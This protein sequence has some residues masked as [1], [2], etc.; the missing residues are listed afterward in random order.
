MIQLPLT[1]P[2]WAA[3]CLDEARIFAGDAG[4][5]SLAIGL[6][7]RNVEQGTGGPFGAAIF[8]RG[9]GELVSIGMNL[10][11]AA[12][13]SVLHAEMVAIMQAEAKIGSFTLASGGSFELFTSCEPCA[14]CLGGILWSGVDRLVCAAAA[15]DARAIGFDEGPVYPESY[16]YLEERGIEIVRGYMRDEG[17]EVLELYRKRGG[18]LYNRR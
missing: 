4:K 16:R 3:S 7:R 12:N 11:V 17:R 6:A 14:M 15:E 8:K 18:V 2:E 9:S 13:N 1:L 5:M 10:V